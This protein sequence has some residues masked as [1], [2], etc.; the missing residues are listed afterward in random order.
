MAGVLPQTRLEYENGK[1]VLRISR[2][3]QALDGEPLRRRLRNVARELGF[4][5]DL[6]VSAQLDPPK[7]SLFGGLLG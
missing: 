2:Q 7:S 4:I 1:L 5:P 6:Q 3:L